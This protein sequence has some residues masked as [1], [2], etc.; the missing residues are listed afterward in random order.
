MIF[1]KRAERIGLKVPPPPPAEFFEGTACQILNGRKIADD[2]LMQCKNQVGIRKRV[3]HLT[4]VLVG[5][6]LASHTYVTNKEKAF[7]RAGFSSNVIRIAGDTTSCSTQSLLELIQS[8]NRDHHVDGVLVQLP[9]PSHIDS[10]KVVNAIETKKDVDGFTILNAGR[11]YQGETD[12]VLPCTPFGAMVLLSSYQVPLSGKKALVIGRSQIVGRP[13]AQMLLCANATVAM[14]HSQTHNLPELCL[15]ADVI[16]S[17][18]GTQDTVIKDFTSPGAVVVDVGMN[19]DNS[20][21]LCGD[22]H[23]N[24]R[25]HA[26]LLTPVPGGVGPLTIA[27]L[28]VNTAISAWDS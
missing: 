25:E 18:V 21:Q 7:L 24:V 20:G 17:A 3:P 5:D 19:R 14:A 10:K 2:L 23:K 12:G 13:M 1:W 16:V 8:L 22:V 6:N 15:W 4:V 9:L 27:M 26:S 11:L 28:C